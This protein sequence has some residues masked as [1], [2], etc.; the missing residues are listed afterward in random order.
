VDEINSG[1]RAAAQRERDRRE[2]LRDFLSCCPLVQAAA[3]TH[4]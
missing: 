3:A 4:R 1:R 2:V